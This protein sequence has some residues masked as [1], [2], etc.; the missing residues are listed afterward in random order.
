MKKQRGFVVWQGQSAIDNAPIVLI[1]I[2]GRNGHHNKKTGA[3][4]QTYILR[5]DISPV[6]AI[7]RGKDRSICGACIHSSKQNG[8]LGSCYVRI[9]TGPLQVWKAYKRGVYPTLKPIDSQAQCNGE[10]V[11]LGTYGDPGALPLLVWSHL[12]EHAKA[13]TGYTHLWP[14]T[15]SGLAR[16]C[17]ASCDN[18]GQA[19]EAQSRGWRSFTV[20]PTSYT[21]KPTNSFLCPASEQAG[22]K[23]TC[24]ECL[25]CGGLSSTNTASV[26]IPVHGVQYKQARFTSLITIGG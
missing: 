11:R 6:E 16:Y 10:L 20:V 7:Q 1:A 2:R 14:T 25:A 19:E 15:G 23:L 24:S 26:Y 13:Y 9:D 8:G 12:L 4:L 5:S 17:M 22:K 18:L 3:L 21:S